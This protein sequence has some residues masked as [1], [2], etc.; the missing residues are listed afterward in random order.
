M[1]R[2]LRRMSRYGILGRYLPAFG[3]IVGQMQHDLFHSYTVDAH[4]LQVIENMRRFLRP[5][6]DERFPGDQPRRPASAE[7]R[8]ALHRRPVPRYRQ[9]AR[10]RP[11]GARRRRCP[12]VLRGS[13]ASAAATASSSSGWCATTCS[14]P[15]CRSARTYPTPTVV[16]QFARHVG[17]QNRLDYLFTLTV[18]DIN[19]TNPKL[20][21]AWRGSLLRQLY[22]ETTRALRRG[23]ENPVDRRVG[24]RDARGRGGSSS[25]AASPARSSRAVERARR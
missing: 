21:N 20:W 17:D 16:Q 3:R 14:C 13:T 8:A 2:Q 24:R 1:T 7:D 23:L 6:N 19:G 12:G 5:E 9:G 15:P 11:L 10:R 25:T 22:T 18:A 4:T